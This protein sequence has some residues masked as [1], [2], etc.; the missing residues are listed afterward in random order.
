MD[1]TSKCWH[2]RRVVWALL[3]LAFSLLKVKER[4]RS[5]TITSVA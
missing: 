4:C 3:A 5:F 1:I 2:F